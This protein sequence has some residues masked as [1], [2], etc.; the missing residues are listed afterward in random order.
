M[1][2]H[3]YEYTIHF[4]IQRSFSSLPDP[5]CSPS[6]A[7]PLLLCLFWY[8]LN[9]CSHYLCLFHFVDT[10]CVISYRSTLQRHKTFNLK[11]TCDGL[12]SSYIMGK[13]KMMNRNLKLY[14]LQEPIP[15]ARFLSPEKRTNLQFGQFWQCPK[16]T[17]KFRRRPFLNTVLGKDLPA[18]N[19]QH[20]L[21]KIHWEIQVYLAT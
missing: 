10:V 14:S 17:I 9:L 15:K 19:S 3:K 21:Q 6:S 1:Q 4:Y 7:A 16:E 12:S 5:C 18:A 20:F 11:K 13:L 8:S 2:I